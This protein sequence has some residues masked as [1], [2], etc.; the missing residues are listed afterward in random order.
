MLDF[1]AKALTLTKARLGITS[2]VRDELIQANIDAIV[3]ELET[4]KGLS[5][6]W[7][8]PD[9]LMFVVDY[10]AWRYQ[11]VSLV[12]PTGTLEMPS[13]IMFRLHALM[14]YRGE[15]DV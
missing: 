7:D 5:L 9:H 15:G 12:N 4:T 13:H 11:S 6:D 14:L 1:V 10:A 8:S 3:R 2:N